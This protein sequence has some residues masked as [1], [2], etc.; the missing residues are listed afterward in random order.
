MRETIVGAALARKWNATL[1]FNER[2]N[3]QDYDYFL[4]NFASGRSIRIEQT[5]EYICPSLDDGSIFIELYT[6]T[7][8]PGQKKEGK[9]YYSKSDKLLFVLNKTHQIIILDIKKIRELIINLEESNLLKIYD[10]ADHSGWIQ[11]HDSMPSVGAIVPVKDCMQAD[12]SC[13]VFTFEELNINLQFYDQLKF[14]RKNS[15]S[16]DSDE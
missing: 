1:S 8:Q 9:L 4:C 12:P 6:Y 2:G 11:K 5:D 15:D 13:C 16:E 3:L 7:N 14:N 10:P